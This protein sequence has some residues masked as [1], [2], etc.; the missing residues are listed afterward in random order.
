M[1]ISA[2]RLQA[3]SATP[4]AELATSSK[5]ANLA[6]KD[7]PH[8]NFRATIEVPTTT[9]LTVHLSA[10]N[11][12]IAPITG[13]KDI[14]VQ[15]GDVGISIPNSNDYA[16]VDADVKVGNINAGPFGHSSSGFSSHLKWSGAGKYT[17][18]ASVGTGNLELKH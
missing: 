2:S 9:D 16:T 17:L 10:G 18:H 11:L 7:T 5:R 4:L 12:E 3:T 13:D 8:N 15:V 1:I 14:D 6:I